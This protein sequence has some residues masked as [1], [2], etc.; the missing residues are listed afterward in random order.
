MTR[1]EA[2]K[3]LDEM[4]DSKSLKKHCLTIALVMEAYASKL[5]EPEDLWYNTGLLHDAD[6]DRFPDQHPNIIVKRL[7]ESGDFE[8]AY[9]I[10][11]HFTKWGK[12]Y[13]KPLEKYLLAVDEL[14]GLIV[15]ASLMRPTG[16]M[17]MTV[18]SVKKKIKSKGFAAGGDRNEIDKGIEIADLELSEHVQF[19]IDVLENSSEKLITI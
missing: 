4:I 5:G 11:A 3:I 12:K 10:S 6:Y 18:K 17:G 14:T 16:M 8:M 19:I 15:A 7:E 2:H 9:A 1:E 13:H